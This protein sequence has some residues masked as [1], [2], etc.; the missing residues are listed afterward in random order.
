[1]ISNDIFEKSSKFIQAGYVLFVLCLT[2]GTILAH[3]D[4]KM[5]MLAAAVVFGWSQIGSV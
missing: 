3:F 5:A 4:F 1:M 2:M